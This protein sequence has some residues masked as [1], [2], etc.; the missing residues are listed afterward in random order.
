MKRIVILGSTGSIGRMALEV[1]S[2]HRDRFNVVGLVAGRNIDLLEKQVKDFGPEVV[3]VAGEGEARELRRRL[4]PKPEVHFG[5]EGVNAVAAHDGSDFVLSSMVGFSGLIPTIH[6]IRAGKVIGLAN[7]ETL[8]IAGRIVTEEARMHGARI[9]PVDSEHSAIFQCVEGHDRGQVKRVILTASGGPFMG[10]TMEDLKSVSPEEALKHPKWNMGKKVTI[11]SATLMNKGLEVI[12]ASHLF[13]LPAEKIDVLVHP[14]SIVHSMVEFID[15]GLLAQI[16]V[17][18]M[19]GPIGYALSYPERLDNTVPH[20]DFSTV[21][22]LT[23]HRPDA[24]NFPCLRFAYEALKEGGTM[25]SVLNAANEAVVDAFLARKIKF[26]D[27]PVIINEVMHSHVK[28]SAAALE[29]VIEADRWAREKAED[30]IKKCK[31]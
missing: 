9:L 1:I 29:G 12:E 26:T 14:Q 19:R 6:A 13:D 16:S 18:D 15:G 20:L 27:I 30:Y 7:K 2:A 8:V 31:P 5:E 25:P 24:E 3:A 23:F 4:G 10:K 17:P 22:E 21:G 28:G 11:D